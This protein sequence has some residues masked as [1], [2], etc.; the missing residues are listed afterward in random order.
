MRIPRR[1]R[2][3]C[4]AGALV[5]VWLR[6]G[7]LDAQ[8]QPQPGASDRARE[9]FQLGY[10]DL[11]ADR[12]SDALAHF[13]ASYELLP[14]PEMLYNIGLASRSLGRYLF[15]LGAWS[16]YLADPSVHPDDA[17]LAS[18]RRDIA[19]ME[20]RVAH[21]TVR[22]TPATA[23]LSVDGRPQSQP[24]VSLDPGTHVVLCEQP[25]H[26]AA[27]R[28]VRLGAG[29]RA[30]LTFTLDVSPVAPAV[31]RTEAPVRPPPRRVSS[32]SIVRAPLFWAG[33]GLTVASA[34]TATALGFSGNALRD[35]YLAQC[36]GQARRPDCPAFQASTQSR[37]DAR[38]LGANLA[39][40]LTGV[41]AALAALGVIVTLTHRDVATAPRLTLGPQRIDLEVQW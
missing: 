9:E 10:R 16:R 36:V 37:L 33:V 39:W 35:D 28:E 6:A 17:R 4:A 3:W 32:P 23:T 7:T 13:E 27:R 18:I 29:E 38:A 1:S 8:P 24:E 22:V 20:S 12:Y 2:S 19:E 30:E 31:V 25:G 21:L 40:G 34:A 26:V 14:N 41:G 11:V 5:A 15:A